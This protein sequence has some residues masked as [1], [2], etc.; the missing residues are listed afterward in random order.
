MTD[1]NTPN[2]GIESRPGEAPLDWLTRIAPE[3]WDVT[4]N[5]YDL[6]FQS[7]DRRVVV[8]PLADRTVWQER[9]ETGDDAFGDRW[10]QREVTE[11]RWHV[12]TTAGLLL[13]GVSDVSETDPTSDDERRDERNA[14]EVR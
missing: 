4:E 9:I 1:E 2:H 14:S 12:Q 5:G 10:I 13:W 6:V 3:E 7:G 8:D 11:G